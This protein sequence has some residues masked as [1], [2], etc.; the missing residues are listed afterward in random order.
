[1]SVALQSS[2]GTGLR[3]ILRDPE[4]GRVL[5]HAATDAEGNASLSYSNCGHAAL[6]LD[7]RGATGSSG[8][9]AAI[10]RP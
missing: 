5:A 6:T 7:V 4:R 9:R 2:P 3:L 1:V 8:F 10:T